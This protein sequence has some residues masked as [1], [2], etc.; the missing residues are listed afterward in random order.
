MS[1]GTFP[2]GTGGVGYPTSGT[3]LTVGYLIDRTFDLLL[4]AAREERNKC[5]T[6][7]DSTMTTIQVQY[8]LKNLARGTYVAIDDEVM[9][10]W[11]TTPA[12]GG[13][14]TITVQRGDKGTIPTTHELGSI[15]A[16][17]P[18]F[19]R[20]Q[21]RQTLKDEIRS[22]G[23][24]VFQVL[25]ADLDL[26]DWVRGY[27]LGILGQ[28]FYVLGVTES[29]DVNQ[30]LVPDNL[31]VDVQYRIDRSANAASFPS[32]SA[33]YV[34]SPQGVFS[35][36][37]TLHVTYAAP[38]DVDSSFLDTDLIANTGMDYSDID[39]APYGAAWRLAASRE[40]R[41]ML[42]EAQGQNSDLQNYPAGYMVKAAE[43]FKQLRDSRLADAIERLRAQ[44]PVRRTS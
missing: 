13:Y 9:Y 29:P 34:T 38:I 7:V 15:I 21:V 3:D 37:R 23:P 10:V 2:Y 43:D 17:N 32:G 33:L 8:D 22:W 24:Q 27:D 41:R 6:Y 5:A 39:I 4:G 26:T 36:P 19:T 11:D 18:Y 42:T 16:V 28:W 1:Y 40:V 30:G 35:T 31:W 44:Y 25:T 14:S 12:S 20:Y